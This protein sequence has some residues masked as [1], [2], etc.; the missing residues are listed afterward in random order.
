MVG[1]AVGKVVTGVL[2]AQVHF[3]CRWAD[4]WSVEENRASSQKVCH[5]E[6]KWDGTVNDLGLFVTAYWK[7]DDLW[8][9]GMSAMCVKK[10]LVAT[11]R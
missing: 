1:A 10:N 9:P 3:L 8:N 6:E 7:A 2:E 11:I 4:K 5:E